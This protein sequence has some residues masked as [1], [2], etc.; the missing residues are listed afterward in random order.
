MDCSPLTGYPDFTFAALLRSSIR[1]ME[2]TGH[3]DTAYDDKES[4]RRAMQAGAVAFLAKPFNDEQL[5]QWIRSALRQDE[6]A[7]ERT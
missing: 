7:T 3:E 2:A 1:G 6:G 4:R 5:L